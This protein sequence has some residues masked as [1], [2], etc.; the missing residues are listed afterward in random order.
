MACKIL[1]TK[2]Q[3]LDKIYLGKESLGFPLARDTIPRDFKPQKPA[4]LNPI[5][6]HTIWHFPLQKSEERERERE[7][8]RE[9]KRVQ[10]KNF[11]KK[12]LKAFGFLVS[13]KE[14]FV[15][16]FSPSLSHLAECLGVEKIQEKFRVLARS[17][18]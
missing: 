3:D 5:L 9:I 7:R 12:P 10:A 6:S 4:A 13:S 2:Y 1:R 18:G 8:A 17:K 15:Q 16:N 14:R 11:V